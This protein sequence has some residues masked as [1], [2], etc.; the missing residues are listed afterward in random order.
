[1][2]DSKATGGLD[3]LSL[4]KDS[5]IAESLVK[6]SAPED[7][8]VIR[9]ML[10]LY[11]V[12]G[13]LIGIC[14]V[15]LSAIKG[16]SE[17]MSVLLLTA[18]TGVFSTALVGL[19]LDLS[20]SR[21]RAAAEREAMKPI[22]EEFAAERGS[23]DRE[24]EALKERI[25]TS[26]QKTMQPFTE[27]HENL[28]RATEKLSTVHERLVA[29]ERLGLSNCHQSR[30]EALASFY[31]YAKESI[32]SHGAKENLYPHERVCIA[33][34][35]AR[36]LIGYIDRNRS[37]EQEDW[38]QLVKENPGHFAFL[39]TH[40]AYAHLRQ[41]AEERAPGAIELE[42]LKTA[43]YLFYEV[44]MK[45]GDL[46]L[47]RGS[48][49]VFAIRTG[50]HILLN[51]YPY[52][53]MAM[54][55]LCLEFEASEKTAFI[56][57]FFNMHFDH[58]WAFFDQSSMLVDGKP[59]VAGIGQF[60]DILD[61]FGDCT[62]LG[63][64]RRLRL[65]KSQVEELDHFTRNHGEAADAESPFQKYLIEHKIVCSGDDE[66]QP[67]GDS[68]STSLSGALALA[69]GHQAVAKADTLAASDA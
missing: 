40:P 66:Y 44:K 18:G 63:N 41:P 10:A 24:V 65:T 37:K 27:L 55:T 51:P 16:I 21:V 64:P 13:M 6:S 17:W 60:S 9:K 22:L 46:R 53:R 29:F 2:N 57:D 58:T 11:M 48:P 31:K 68:G 25:S 45:A 54:D 19:V 69:A 39:L 56:S 47:Y 28:Q 26:V 5:R 32:S 3:E 61:A 38:R 62:V 59:L 43:V 30:A 35:S 49:T 34:S 4:E 50:R 12:I 15:T 36:G 42:I 14:L 8:F 33:S 52:G 20:W 67:L 23:L 1:M 7:R